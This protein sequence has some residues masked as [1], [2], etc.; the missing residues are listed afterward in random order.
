[1]TTALGRG[2]LQASCK[3][4]HFLCQRRGLP[5][6]STFLMKLKVNWKIKM[7]TQKT[8]A[9]VPGLYLRVCYQWLACDI[10]MNKVR[11]WGWINVSFY[12]E[13]S[14][15]SQGIHSLL[16]QYQWSSSG[17]RNGA[18]F[19]TLVNVDG[20]PQEM[21]CRF[22]WSITTRFGSCS[23]IY[24]V[25][26]KKCIVLWMVTN[27]TSTTLCKNSNR[28]KNFRDIVHMAHWQ[29]IETSQERK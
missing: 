21:E 29:W 23:H 17:R 20:P 24:W 13:H 28:K 8:T 5:H 26:G 19:E 2:T 10:L 7:W 15:G 9:L 6:L 4:S 25:S 18:L 14:G 22:G 27:D 16:N 3:H 12:G 11:I 1:M